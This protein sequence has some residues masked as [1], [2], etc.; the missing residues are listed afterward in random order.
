MTLRISDILHNP[1][2]F[3]PFQGVKYTIHKIGRQISAEGQ[4]NTIFE[5]T[6]QLE[7]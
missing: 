3:V 6:A 7:D 4:K 1:T 2:P 5:P